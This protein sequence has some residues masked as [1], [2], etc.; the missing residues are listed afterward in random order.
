MFIQYTVKGKER[1]ERLGH[2]QEDWGG[3]K[4]AE[5][6]QGSRAFEG[7]LSEVTGGL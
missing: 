2:W 1:E 4:A 3:G 6:Q 5:A 7:V